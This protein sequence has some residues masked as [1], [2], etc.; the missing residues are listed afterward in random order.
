MDSYQTMDLREEINRRRGGEDSRTTIECNRERCQDIEGCHLE[1][2]IDLHALVGARQVAHAPLPLAPREFWGVHG[3]GPTP[4]YGGLATQVLTP[5]AKEVR[6]DG[7]PR[8]VP[9]DLLH[10]NPHGSRE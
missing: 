7:K 9:I 3:I 6:W 4:T 1:R 5:P 10:L 8:R 2:D